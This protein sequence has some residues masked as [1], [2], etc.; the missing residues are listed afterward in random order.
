MNVSDKEISAVLAFYKWLRN[1]V[2]WLG[3]MTLIAVVASVLIGAY[4]TGQ[5]NA[6]ARGSCF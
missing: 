6:P 3:V 5:R 4:K 1:L 2:I